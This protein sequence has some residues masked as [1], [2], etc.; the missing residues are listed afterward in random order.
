MVH[1]VILYLLPGNSFGF[2]YL[3]DDPSQWDE[4]SHIHGGLCYSVN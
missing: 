2:S 1:L 3:G 4:V